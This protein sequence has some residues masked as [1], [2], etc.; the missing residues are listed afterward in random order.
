M[1][2]SL[3]QSYPQTDSINAV[4]R[5]QPDRTRRRKNE[6]EPISFLGLNT[7]ASAAMDVFDTLRVTLSEPAPILSKEI[8]LLEQKTD[9]VWNPVDF[10]LMQD[11]LNPM[12]YY[13]HKPI[14]YEDEYRLTVDS[15]AIYSYYGKW[16]NKIQD[17][18]KVK[19]R[20][21]YGFLFIRVIGCET[22]A[23]VELLNKSGVPVRRAEVKDGGA[24]FNNLPLN[25]YYA[26]IIMDANGNGKWDTGE[27][28]SKRQPEEVFYYP[29]YFDIITKN[30]ESEEDWNIYDTPLFKQK[31]MDI[32]QNKPKEV[33]K[34][35]KDYRNEGRS[36]SSSS[37]PFGSRMGF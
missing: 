32:I 12:L 26:R 37:N 16:N 6:K 11:T 34:K 19:A 30:W 10:T 13:L 28:E 21:E 14:R 25:R 23:Y 18:I 24:L 3:N 36:S 31:P 29:K 17:V 20:N 15:A 5:K 2:D 35:N 27:Y 33:T 7:N 1:P 8:F 9:T 22:N 4:Y